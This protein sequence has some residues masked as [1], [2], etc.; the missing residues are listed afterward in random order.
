MFILCPFFLNGILVFTSVSGNRTL[1]GRVTSSETIRCCS[2][3]S[4][5]RIS[6]RFL[7]RLKF[8]SV[9]AISHRF[10]QIPYRSISGEVVLQSPISARNSASNGA[11]SWNLNSSGFRFPS[12]KCPVKP[13]RNSSNA[14]SPLSVFPSSNTFCPYSTAVQVGKTPRPFRNG[15]PTACSHHFPIRPYV[16]PMMTVARCPF[17]H[18]MPHPSILP[19]PKDESFPVPIPA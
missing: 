8:L 16:P 1:S 6:C 4:G 13:F 17:P 14:L 3:E 19:P 7:N 18:R 10:V 15:A 9:G 5:A 12:K 2:F 11:T